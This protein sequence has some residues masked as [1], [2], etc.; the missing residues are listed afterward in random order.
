MTKFISTHF[1][2]AAALLCSALAL[3]FTLVAPAF[4]DDCDGDG[5]DDCQQIAAGAADM[6][7]NGVLDVCETARGD[8]NLDGL[9]DGA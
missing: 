2:G 5:V 1:R 9:V 6:N 8:L 7:E 4:A 3:A